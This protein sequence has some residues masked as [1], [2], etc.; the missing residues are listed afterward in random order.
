MPLDELLAKN[1][2][3]QMGNG[4]AIYIDGIMDN[5]FYHGMTLSSFFCKFVFFLQKS[6][7]KDV[8]FKKYRF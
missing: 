7:Q 2:E 5:D 3:Y 4:K 1:G 6:Q 8:F